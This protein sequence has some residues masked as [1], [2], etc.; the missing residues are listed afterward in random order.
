[1]EIVYICIG[2]PKVAGDSFGA[3]VGD[4]L[5]E[6]GIN[7]VV[8]GCSQY[9]INS[10]NITNY[11]EFI[12]RKHKNALKISVDA[13]LGA[14]EHCNQVKIVRGGLRPGLALGKKIKE[15]GDFSVLG[16]V[17]EKTNNPIENLLNCDYKQIL[18]MSELISNLLIR[19]NLHILEN[20]KKAQTNF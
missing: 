20:I 19:L 9:P 12:E 16:M 17:A 6:S 1:M 14:K 8:Y 7:A 15:I 18:K 13:C 3:L 11:L 10:R 2:T 5:I 4:F